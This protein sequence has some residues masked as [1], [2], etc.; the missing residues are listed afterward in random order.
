MKI[1]FTLIGF[2]CVCLFN[3]NDISRVF[4]Y[5]NGHSVSFVTFVASFVCLRMEC[6]NFVLNNCSIIFIF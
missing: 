5:A 6:K 2:V 3:L 1:N 4:E